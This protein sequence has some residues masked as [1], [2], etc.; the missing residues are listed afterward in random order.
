MLN[1]LVFANGDA[2]TLQ[3]LLTSYT[4]GTTLYSHGSVVASSTMTG[5]DLTGSH[6][7]ATA[8]T[9]ND[10]L[11]A[12]AG[13]DT[14]IAGSGNDTLIGGVGATTY[15]VGAGSGVT[16]ISQSNTADILRFGAGITASNLSL[17]STV[18]ANG[19]TTV[20]IQ[21]GGGGEIVIEGY[22]SGMLDNLDFAN[23]SSASLGALLAQATTGSNAMSS[24]VSIRMPEGARNSTLTGSAISRRPAMT[25]DDLIT[26]NSGND[27]LVAGT[28]NDT[29]VAAAGNDT[30]TGGVGA[31]TYVFNQQ[32]GDPTTR[33]I[34]IQDSGSDDILQF[35]SGIT[36]ANI[37]GT[38][39]TVNG[40]LVVTLQVG[41]LGQVVIDGGSLS[42][43]SFANGTTGKLTALVPIAGTTGNTQY[44]AA[45]AT[46]ASGLTNLTMTGSANVTAT[47]NSLN[48]VI[49]ANNGNDSLVSGSGND[50][51]IAGTGSDTL[52]GGFPSMMRYTVAPTNSTTYTIN[53]EPA[54]SRSKIPVH[55]TSWCSA[56]AYKKAISPVSSPEVGIA[57]LT[58]ENI[59]TITDSLGGTITIDGEIT[60]L[61]AST[62]YPTGYTGSVLNSVS[63]AN[64]D[65]LTLS[66]MESGDYTEGTSLY[67]WAGSNTTVP[68]GI[69]TAYILGS[70]YAGVTANSLNEIS[71]ATPA[72]TIWWR[73]AA[74]TPYKAAA[75]TIRSPLERAMRP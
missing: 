61:S 33:T 28:A 57:Y 38:S 37:T 25:V 65:S 32:S 5:I 8:N 64:G 30:L 13:N 11:Q 46:L 58:D 17:T 66:K 4:E 12:N 40:T 31:T 6:A 43:L 9:L 22:G 68:G 54:M 21:G 45:S 56:P 19:Q 44:A 39:A 69:T 42:T 7:S 55:W 2:P 34:T 67:Y 75:V 63:F 74:A 59:I 53:P 52:V 3:Q 71:S 1:N 18:A 48:D 15:I 70:N 14:L 72:R 27:S 24:A 20:T 26:A 62:G 36:A 60:D 51:L 41:T 16:T 23:G 73:V 29:L 49:I 35:G 47:G 50:T 10:T